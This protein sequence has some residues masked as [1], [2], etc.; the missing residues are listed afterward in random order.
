[1]SEIQIVENFSTY[2]WSKLLIIYNFHLISC[3]RLFQMKSKYG[4]TPCFHIK[5]DTMI[6]RGTLGTPVGPFKVLPGSEQVFHNTCFYSIWTNFAFLHPII[7]V[8][9][10]FIFIFNQDGNK[11]KQLQILFPVL[12][13]CLALISVKYTKPQSCKTCLKMIWNVSK[14]KV[15]KTNKNTFHFWAI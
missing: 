12:I 13:S 8:K 3:Y 2:S 10:V 6:Y 1:M 4:G 14:M 9:N 7:Q 15:S 11:I 5:D